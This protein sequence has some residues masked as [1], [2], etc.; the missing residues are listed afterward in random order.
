MA[1]KLKQL[2]EQDK[3]S[4]ENFL[5]IAGKGHMEY[6]TG[7]PELFFQMSPNFDKNDSTMVSVV[8]RKDPDQYLSD[9]EDLQSTLESIFIGVDPQTNSDEKLYPA[10]YLFIYDTFHPDEQKDEEYE[11]KIETSKAYNEVGEL[12]HFM[13]WT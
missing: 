13:E 3:L 1:Y 6:Y 10:D 2:V 9:D 8:C 12:C 7:V 11:A 5:V 4:E